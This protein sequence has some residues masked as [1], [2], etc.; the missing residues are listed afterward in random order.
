MEKQLEKV[1]RGSIRR[2]PVG[3][4][5]AAL[6]VSV[7]AAPNPNRTEAKNNPAAPSSQA[8]PTAKLKSAMLELPLAF[9]ANRGQT[10]GK[11]EF[12]T[13][14]QNFTIFLMPNETVMRG[15]NQDVLRMKLQ[16]ANQSPKLVGEDKQLKVTNY[17]FGTDSS[18][19]LEGI[20]NY[21]QV[22]YQ[23]VYSGIDMVYHSD[24]RQ[25]E[26]DFVV[27]PGA[28]PNK[29]QVAFQGASKIA[30]TEQGELKLESPAGASVHHK[31]VVYQMING[32][33]RIIDGE[34]TLA[35]NLVGFKLG[36]YDHDQA[37]VIDPTLNVLSWFGGVLNDEASGIATSALPNGAA[38]VFVGRSQSATLPGAA[39]VG[40]TFD[41]DAFATGLNSAG[42]AILWTTFIGGNGDDAA[43]GVAMDNQGFAYIVGYTNSLNFPAGS[44]VNY[45]AFIVKL[46]AASGGLAA[47]TLY[48]GFLVDQGTSIALDYSTF[49]TLANAASI[50]NPATHPAVVP[51]VVIGGFTNGGIGT[52]GSPTA[53][54]GKTPDGNQKNFNNCTAGTAGCGTTDGFVAIFSNSLALLHH[55]YLGGGG[56][57]QVNGVAADLWGNIYAT[58]IATPAV[59]PN[60]PVTRGIAQ[61]TLRAN[62]DANTTAPL[63]SAVPFVVKY[64]CTTG[65]PAIGVPSPPFGFVNG[66]NSQLPLCGGGNNLNTMGNS[67][68]FGGGAQGGTFVNPQQ[69]VLGQNGVTDAALGIAVDQN[70]WGSAA[71]AGVNGGAGVNAR[72]TNSSGFPDLVPIEPIAN[73]NNG[74]Q[75]NLP[76]GGIFLGAPNCVVSASNVST[77][78]GFEPGVAG[79]HVYVVGIT[80]SRDFAASLVLNASCEVAP[81]NSGNAVPALCP[82]PFVFGA[83]IV[84]APALP[85]L[86]FCDPMGIGNCPATVPVPNRA[87]LR[88]QT[89]AN[90]TNSGQ[91]QG[92]LASFQF[93]AITQA[94]VTAGPPATGAVTAITTLNPPTIPNYLIL[95]PAT[96]PAAINTGN[97]PLFTT[98]PNCIEGGVNQGAVF[99]ALAGN[100]LSNFGCSNSAGIGVACGIINTGTAAAPIATA[101]GYL[102]GWNA[103]A[104]DSDEQVYVIGQI[105]MSGAAPATFGTGAPN[106]LALEIERIGPYAN[107][108]AN[109][110]N[111]Q[112]WCPGGV[113]TPVNNAPCAMPLNNF[114]NGVS[115]GTDF[116]VDSIAPPPAL[117][118]ACATTPSLPNC[119]NA[120][121]NSQYGQILPGAPPSPN[122]NAPGGLGNGIAVN[123]TRAAFFVGTSTELTSP[124]NTST[125]ITATANIAGGS[126]TGI[127]ITGVGSGYTA[128]P[129]CALQ[130]GG[131]TGANCSLL[132][133]VTVNVAAVTYNFAID[134]ATGSLVLKDVTGNTPNIA[135]PVPF[136][137]NSCV[138][139]GGTGYLAA[140][141]VAFSA[142]PT[143]APQ[144]VSF[145]RA[146][147]AGNPAPPLP[148]FVGGVGAGGQN[149][150][151]SCATP[152]CAGNG[153]EDVLFGV[154][155]FFDAIASPTA[156]NFTATVNSF[157]SI[158]A[159]NG[160]TGA[161]AKVI[162]NYTDWQGQPLNIPPGCT[163]TPNIPAG[164]NTPGRAFNVVPVNGA[165]NQFQVTVNSTAATQASPADPVS[166]PGVVTSLVVFSKSG[167]C[168]GVGLPPLE[169]WDP[170]TLTLTVSAPLNLAS[171]STFQIHSLLGTGL[172][173][174][175]YNNPS[176][177][178]NGTGQ[179]LVANQQVLTAVDVTTA[180]SSG[181]INFTAQIV[182]GLN[183]AGAVASA[184]TVPT[185]V[186]IIYSA[187]GPTQATRVPVDVN[188]QILAELPT[189]TYTAW[190]MFTPSPETPDLPTSQSTAC[191][192]STTPVA[193]GTTSPAC[194]PIIITI[195]PSV[196]GSPATLVFRGST[197]PQQTP[198]QIANPTATPY[199]FTAQYQPVPVFG[200]ALPISA[201]SYVG[202]AST[203]TPA[204]LTTTVAGTVPAGGVFSLP[205]SINPAGLPTGVYTGQ[206]VF[207]Q[208]TAQPGSPTQPATLTTLPVIV[209]VG[210]AA[211]ED[212]PSGNGLGLM[213]PVNVPP[214]GTGGSQGAAPGTPGSYPLT[215]FVPSGV[216]P[217]GFHQIPNPTLIQVT[218][219][220]NVFTTGFNLNAPAAAGTAP[221]TNAVF[222][223]AV[224]FT[225]VGQ[226]F[227]GANTGCN[228]T[229][230]T[231]NALASAPLGPPCIWDIWV[232]A[233]QLNSTT[234][235]PQAGCPGNGQGISGTITFTNAGGSFP[236]LNFVVPL[237]VCVTDAPELVLGMP[238]TFPNPTYGPT[239]GTGFGNCNNIPNPPGGSPNNACNLSQ[240]SNL[241]PGFPQSITE[242]VLAISGGS[243][244]APA[245]TTAPI[246]LLAQVGNSSQI[247]KILDIHTNGGVVPSATIAPIGVQFATIQPLG[248]IQ[249]GPAFLGPASANPAPNSLPANSQAGAVIGTAADPF[250]FIGQI[251]NVG[252]AGFG[253]F[254][255]SGIA[256]T[257]G[258]AAGPAPI[259]P[260]M[261]TFAICVNT[262]PVGN[263]AGT[264]S[265]TVT[266]NGA[267]V[268]PIIIPVNMI[269]G[270]GNPG[271]P[272]PNTQKFSQVGI[273][274]NSQ[275]LFAL[276][277]SGTNAFNLPG[278]RIEQPFGVPGDIGVAGD[279]DGTGTVRFGVYRPSNG[280][281]YLDMNNNGKWDGAGAGL[282]ADIQFGAPSATCNPT[283]G[284]S[285]A[286]CGDIPVVGD[287]GGTGTSRLGIFRGG[288]FFLDN[289]NPT[290]NGFTGSHTSF[291]TFTFGQPG[292]LPVAANWNG[293]G[294]A[295][296]IG[297]YR[298]GTW[299]VNATGDG[300]YHATDPVYHFGSAADIPVTGNWGASI[301]NAVSQPASKR[302]G[303]FN[304][305]GQWFV[306]FNGDHIFTAPPDLSFPYGEPGDLP[307]VGLWT[308]P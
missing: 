237:T 169:S 164:Q 163:I 217:N 78:G 234:T 30:I 276:N 94:V 289:V 44:A 115:T 59:A 122:P 199:I 277:Q 187:G 232:D 145:L 10:D 230:A 195:G 141:V 303:V 261:Q 54:L 25:L 235:T 274:R 149:A 293:N 210:P 85:G 65:N 121:F 239:V 156:I 31:P 126:V 284:P 152:P 280:H 238:N 46:N 209:Y 299:F 80:A 77:T 104:V 213:L 208:P 243:S 236:F 271:G 167:P 300:V 179:Q 45:D 168:T 218:G 181:P 298:Q 138:S 241:V 51:N 53:T 109:V 3:L 249:G 64:T 102:G 36:A 139:P 96:C 242:M 305:F 40:G 291:A 226:P 190:I 255:G 101:T 35:N 193:S 32:K 105:G 137:C 18:K 27:K 24:Q 47:S 119:S 73:C 70:G 295:D 212:A 106:R 275:S 81:L 72:F 153:P 285:L 222:Q 245:V 116:V 155:Q 99:N 93:P 162:V 251:P 21:G 62:W 111:Q 259:I 123:A 278:D 273:Y 265:T 42:S 28:D 132:P 83:G 133:P 91:T 129:T 117:P 142:P 127:V 15:K 211:G 308:L 197:T 88:I 6:V 147:P 183:W 252:I 176:L 173:N 227:G 61:T 172:V 5:A 100:P 131:G 150:G 17:Y 205:L 231:V 279:W 182:P 144:T 29:I 89:L 26:Y 124:N 140:P 157:N 188:T 178:Y 143:S 219:L 9:E 103:V 23:D 158:T 76:A 14:A 200:T 128:L 224:S 8:S 13:H 287:W 260:A 266:I 37:V 196:S 177:G 60:F 292:D 186:D 55:T 20:P 134:P 281:W 290:A 108:V 170:L 52:A 87:D 38:V 34:Y 202:T 112:N 282:D 233:T 216:G 220:N 301:T 228:G 160:Q 175:Y 253:A 67:A 159:P 257:P 161:N 49:S 75:G 136:T 288:Q 297:V 33:R 113:T 118:V 254:G 244:A 114:P 4:L 98:V 270:A 12:L 146:T 92:W 192:P 120:I 258:F 90:G 110:S 180:T 207:S 130:G 148:A 294:A 7:S 306:D 214:T 247:C 307:V 302:I 263:A 223:N 1:Q 171:E 185:P 66:V 165:P 201:V 95:Q 272:P 43:R 269:V 68:L 71:V 84:A 58:G 2:W 206:V 39:K 189:G 221:T 41:W 57:D 135:V 107:T 56:N 16:N 262:D 198:V 86:P 268:G 256:G 264:F 267:G 154:L 11:V 22:R 203:L 19:W 191:G 229:Y 246:N 82:V 204:S 250:P 79:P 286:A 74:A 283:S 248:G 63:N 50:L 296:Q 69:T 240:P 215:L 184:V 174:E 125:S 194:I 151:E 48:G 225:N 97:A 166:Y 304:P